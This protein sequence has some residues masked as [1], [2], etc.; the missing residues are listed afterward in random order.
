MAELSSDELRFISLPDAAPFA[1]E[2]LASGAIHDADFKIRYGFA[3]KGR[4]VLG[5]Q[6]LGAWLQIGTQNFVLLDP[7][8]AIT[9]AMD[10]FNRAQG[11]GLET[12]MRRWARIA[13]ILPPDAVVE[14]HLR[15]LN[16]VVASGFEVDS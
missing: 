5:V 7:L 1:L 10:E 2:V 9:E 4:R 11:A 15:S 12:R 14:D 13:G 8:Y 16:I 6:R 3:A